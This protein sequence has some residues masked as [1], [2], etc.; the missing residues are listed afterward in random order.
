MSS[1]LPVQ[2]LFQIALELN[3]SDLLNFCAESR[4]NLDNICLKDR[5]WFAKLEKDFPGYPMVRA[6][7]SEN[8]VLLY[9]LIKLAKKYKWKGT[10]LQLNDTLTEKE[11]EKLIREGKKYD[12][13]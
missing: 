11:V 13:F 10:I 9:Q 4:H 6:S 8:Y 2:T 3:L 12:M 7:P 1:K 5:F